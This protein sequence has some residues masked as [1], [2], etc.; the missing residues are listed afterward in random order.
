MAKEIEDISW[1]TGG[2]GLAIL[3][4]D[5]TRLAN[6]GLDGL[7]S[8][9]SNSRT[10]LLK[11]PREIRAFLPGHD[12][13]FCQ[14][15]CE[16]EHFLTEVLEELVEEEEF[17][18]PLAE[19]GLCIRHGQLAVETWKHSRQGNQLSLRLQSQIS[20]LAADLREFIRKRDYKY[21]NE[22]PGREWDSVLRAMRGFVGPKPCG[23]AG[24]KQRS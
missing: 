16:K 7:D 4:E 5:L 12:C 6:S 1:R 22:T 20:E 23:V 24:A 17:Q 8:A 18:K 14:D 15:N 9:R 11:W 21:R 13:M 10:T 3:C 2:F 19:Q